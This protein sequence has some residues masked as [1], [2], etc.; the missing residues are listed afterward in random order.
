MPTAEVEGAL[1]A[2]SLAKSKSTDLKAES[3]TFVGR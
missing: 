1:L 2:V 3:L